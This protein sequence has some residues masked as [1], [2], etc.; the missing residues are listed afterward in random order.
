MIKYL[1]H[2]LIKIEYF[3]LHFKYNICNIFLCKL[4]DDYYEY[5]KNSTKFIKYKYTCAEQIIKNI[6]E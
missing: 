1:N 5:N 4:Y 2:E 6:L 3:D